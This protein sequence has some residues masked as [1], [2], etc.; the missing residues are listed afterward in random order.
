M[1]GGWQ[2]SGV[3]QFQTGT[4]C[5]VF[6]ANDIARVGEVGTSAAANLRR[7]LE[8]E[9]NS[10]DSGSVRQQRGQSE[11][12]FCDDEIQ[13]RRF[14]LRPPP[15]PSTCRKAFA[16]DLRPG[17]QDWNLGLYKKFAVQRASLDW[18]FAPKRSTST[19]IRTGRLP[20]RYSIRHPTT[21]GKVTSKT[22]LSRNLQLSLRFYY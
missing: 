2:I 9:R 18:S 11:P 20:P 16:I 5:S 3:N 1:L 10:D 15:A 13:R 4:P 8:H 19:T 6:S 12:V 14:S 21:F 17:F 7:V 22:T